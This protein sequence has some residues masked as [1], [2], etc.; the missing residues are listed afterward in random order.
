[1]CK[2]F[3]LYTYF[4]GDNM[5]NNIKYTMLY[6]IYGKLLTQKQQDYFKDYYF[7]NFTL[8]E[9]AKNDNVTKAAA[10]KNLKTAK[11]KG[12]AEIIL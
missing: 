3:Q 10:S 7:E 8:D 1:M 6:D 2:V 12:D 5:E 9:I 4:Y 11:E